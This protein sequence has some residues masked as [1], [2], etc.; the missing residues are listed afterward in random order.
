MQ[1]H[2]IN[3]S[4]TIWK[5]GLWKIVHEHILQCLASVLAQQT[6]ITWNFKTVSESVN[7]LIIVL[8]WELSGDIET[9]P[10]GRRLGWCSFII[11]L[12]VDDQQFSTAA[13]LTERLR[14]WRFS[15]CPTRLSCK[16]LNPYFLPVV[17]MGSE[18]LPQIQP[19]VKT[20]LRNWGKAYDWRT[21][22]MKTDENSVYLVTVHLYSLV[23]VLFLDFSWCELYWKG[24]V[25]IGKI[26]IRNWQPN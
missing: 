23:F 3:N 15:K 22:P 17:L 8:V 21:V 6:Q 12:V 24:C 4:N 26:P 7:P 14:L 10:W 1:I 25:V 16:F 5:W 9:V 20:P 18:G 2:N 13:R 11:A 19:R